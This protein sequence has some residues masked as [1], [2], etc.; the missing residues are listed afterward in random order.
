MND[1]INEMIVIPREEFENHDNP[2]PAMREVID[3]LNRYGPRIDD[4]PYEDFNQFPEHSMYIKDMDGTVREKDSLDR[5]YPRPNIHQERIIKRIRNRQRGSGYDS[6]PNN[7]R[8]RINDKL[9]RML[10]ISIKLAL[11]NGFDDDGN[12]IDLSEKKV[13]DSDVKE[14]ILAALTPTKNLYGQDVFI[15]L[16]KKANVDPSLIVNEYMRKTL[17]SNNNHVQSSNIDIQNQQLPFLSAETDK[18]T[19]TTVQRSSVGLSRKR[20]STSSKI[21][22]KYLKKSPTNTN[23]YSLRINKWSKNGNR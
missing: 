16:L 7:R 17:L 12:L 19:R 6:E 1:E 10:H 2:T 8:I 4:D 23:S 13:T 15:K 22:N 20:K 21:K 18:D 5:R 11:I 9:S 3:K 14:L